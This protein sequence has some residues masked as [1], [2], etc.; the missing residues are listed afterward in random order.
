MSLLRGGPHVVR[1]FH[2]VATVDDQGDEIRVPAPKPLEIRTRVQHMGATE[3]ADLSLDPSTTRFFKTSRDLPAAG[4]WSRVEFDGRE[5]DVIGEPQR[6]ETAGAR[7]ATTHTHV[8]IQ[9][10]TPKEAQNG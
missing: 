3:A 5:W 4:A 10:R 8:V 7:A 1:I 2:E 6:Y 9:A